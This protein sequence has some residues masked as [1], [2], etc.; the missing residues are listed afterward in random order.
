MVD[1]LSTIA[2][3][4]NSDG[5]IHRAQI[6]EMTRSDALRFGARFRERLRMRDQERFSNHRTQ[7]VRSQEPS[8]RRNEVNQQDN[9]VAHWEILAITARITRPE[10]SMDCATD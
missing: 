9:Q 10:R 8:E 1:G 5:R 2:T 7:T 6:P 4:N 3:R